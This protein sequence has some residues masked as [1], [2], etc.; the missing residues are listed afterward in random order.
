MADF[1]D[2]CETILD[3]RED[4]ALRE[5]FLRGEGEIDRA[6][7]ACGDAGDVGSGGFAVLFEMNGADEAEVD[8]VAAQVGVEAVLESGEDGGF[9]HRIILG[10]GFDDAFAGN[11]FCEFL[12]KVIVSFSLKVI[13]S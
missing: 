10:P 7:V 13:L 8:D 3:L 1:V 5:V 6:A 11:R 9:G 2:D 12:R 4:V